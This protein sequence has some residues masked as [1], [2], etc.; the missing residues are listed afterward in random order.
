M[1]EH[2][3]VVIP[4]FNEGENIIATANSLGFGKDKNA[5][6]SNMSLILVDN[7]SAD[8]TVFF[9]NNIKAN[10]PNNSVFILSETRQGVVYARHSGNILA[11]E[12]SGNKGWNID[13][14][15]IIQ[16]DA[17]T[18]YSCDY[19]QIVQNIAEVTDENSLLEA[20]V[21]YDVK[22]AAEYDWYVDMCK[23][24]DDKLSNVFPKNLTSDIIVDDKVASYK[25]SA[26]MLWG[27]HKK[28]CDSLGHEIYA[29]TTRLFISAQAHQAKKVMLEEAIAFHSSRKV[30]D[31]PCVIFA[32]AGFPR[33]ISYTREIAQR[34]E[35][36][37]N[38]MDLARKPVLLNKLI[39]LRRMHLL[40]LFSMLPI[41]VGRVTNNIPYIENNIM[42][43]FCFQY[44]PA[45]TI[46]DL[47]DNS[48]Y[49]LLDVFNALK[50]HH[51][52]LDK[53]LSEL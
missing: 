26:Y 36:I 44:L 24:I 52:H 13:N 30:I 14:V 34:F 29:E 6:S 18:T 16:A 21:G 20:R 31:M 25:L 3:F 1:L 40:A 32:T 12:I 17:D 49:F 19:V 22:F 2:T 43:D 27:G 15:L 33:E 50:F 39:S 23:L 5:T 45:R 35:R 10:S 51:D 47:K 53:I 9:L 38:L 28:E 8:N 37:N 46:A 48:G 42:L 11:L 7:N 41:H 4:C